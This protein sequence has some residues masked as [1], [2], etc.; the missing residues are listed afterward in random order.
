MIKF[1]SLIQESPVPQLASSELNG[2][3]AIGEADTFNDTW[4]STCT[5]VQ[6]PPSQPPGKIMVWHHL[7]QI[8]LQQTTK[9]II[10]N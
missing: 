6:P 8:L 9:I 2:K 1:V 3:T 7:L 10:N 5:V 4:C